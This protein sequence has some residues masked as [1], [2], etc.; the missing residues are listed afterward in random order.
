MYFSR[1]KA[2]EWAI[3]LSWVYKNQIVGLSHVV[4][5]ESKKI[6]KEFKIED[7]GKLKDLLGAKLN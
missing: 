3:W 5:V 2:G 1:N 6:G 7:V 4:E